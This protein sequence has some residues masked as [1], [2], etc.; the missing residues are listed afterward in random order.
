MAVYLDDDVVMSQLG[1]A[2]AFACVE[3]AFRLLSDGTAVNAPRRRSGIGPAVLNVM[4][5]MAPTEGV[6]GVKSYPI[7]HQ[8]TT[9]GVV[10]NL[11]VYSMVTG[12]LLAMMKAD[13]LGQLRTGAATAV[14]S[15]ALAREDAK[16]LAVYG[17]GFQAE[18]Q[19]KALM[20]AMPSLEVVHVVGR[21]AKHRDSFIARMQGE[22]DAD[23][24]ASEAEP[25]ARSADIIVTATNSA[26]PVVLGEW[27]AP[28]THINAVGS[29]APAKREVD[30]A[31]LEKAAVVVV[32]DRD[33]AAID[34]GDLLVNEW[35]LDLV[36][37]VGDLLTGR[38]PGRQSPEDITLFESQGIALQDIVCAGLVIS[39]AAERGLGLRIG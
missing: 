33:V 8:D 17:T 31:V 25:A 36:G 29:N 34:C 10:L 5:A 3:R 6:M 23:I 28:G 16:T 24:R 39:R 4:W 18:T 26:D 30:R 9:Q 38:I 13:R 7:V 15:K 19:I 14:A 11:L 20:A 35:N 2:D 1:T 32:D 37:T 21:N 12:E 22:V 27:I